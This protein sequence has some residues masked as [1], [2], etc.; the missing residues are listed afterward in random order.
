MFVRNFVLSFGCSK[1]CFIKWIFDF[2][3][4]HMLIVNMVCTAKKTGKLRRTL[5]A[6]SDLITCKIIHACQSDIRAFVLGSCTVHDTWFSCKSN[7]SLFLQY[8]TFVWAVQGLVTCF[9][10]Q[11]GNT[12]E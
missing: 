9:L 2:G 5:N 12:N 10:C 1:F 4:T 11:D 7:M 3:C 8:Y 6:S